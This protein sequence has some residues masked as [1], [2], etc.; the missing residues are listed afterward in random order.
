MSGECNHCGGDHVEHGC[1]YEPVG[2]LME[3]ISDKIGS[4]C[5]KDWIECL[6]LAEDWERLRKL[7]EFGWMNET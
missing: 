4:L 5:N 1:L 2:D 7:A 6:D 3:R